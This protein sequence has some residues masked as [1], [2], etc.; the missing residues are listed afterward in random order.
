MNIL[1]IFSKENAEMD[2]SHACCNT[3]NQKEEKKKKKTG[4]GKLVLKYKTH[5][6]QHMA[7]SSSQALDIWS[8]SFYTCRHWSVKRIHAA[9]PPSQCCASPTPSPCLTSPSP[10]HEGR[11]CS[12]CWR[13]GSAVSATVAVFW[14]SWWC[15]H[16]RLL[17]CQAPAGD[18]DCI[19]LFLPRIT[20]KTSSKSLL[21]NCTGC[22][23]TLVKLQVQCS[24]W[25]LISM[26]T[27]VARTPSWIWFACLVFASES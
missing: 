21:T 11:G 22:W 19:C 1:S 10:P 7:I 20:I 4:K 3:V 26:K 6:R 18:A 16:Y 2:H 23:T 17:P 25:K 8:D 24:T 12:A 5:Q 13:H 9:T 14:P 15:N 27:P